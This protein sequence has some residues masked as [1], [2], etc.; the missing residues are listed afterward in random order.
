V[1]SHQIEPTQHD[2]SEGAAGS[3]D[4][5]GAV[6]IGA[7]VHD[8][9]AGASPGD[10]EG[11]DEAEGDNDDWVERESRR[12][13]AA[14]PLH[15]QPVEQ[16]VG[17]ESGRA[18]PRPLQLPWAPRILTDID[19]IDRIRSDGIRI[20]Y[21]IAAQRRSIEGLVLLHFFIELDGRVQQIQVA[22]AAHP[23]L[24]SAAVRAIRR[25]RFV[26]GEKNGDRIRTHIQLP[27]RFVLY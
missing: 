25:T 16:L 19:N 13:E 20:R 27:V 4:D 1:Q 8:L 5:A 23:S 14:P 10:G 18:Y 11:E 17:R 12:H 26:P 24:D 3:G 22:Q 21:P 7:T 2:R 6:E 15:L 9:L